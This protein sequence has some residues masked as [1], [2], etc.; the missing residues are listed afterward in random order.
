MKHA[1]AALLL[2]ITPAHAALDAPCAADAIAKAGPLLR[3]HNHLKADDPVDVE[4]DAKALPPVKGPKGKGSLDV[5][6][7]TGRYLKATYRM[8]FIY[9]QTRGSCALMGQEILEVDDPN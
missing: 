8:R 9:A 1:L 5:L 6:E 3:F 4:A 7:V 2:L